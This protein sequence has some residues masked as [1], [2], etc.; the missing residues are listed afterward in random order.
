[1]EYLLLRGANY[2]RKLF[3]QFFTTWKLSICI[4]K[5]QYIERTSCK[6]YSK[7]WMF[8]KHLS[9]LFCGDLQNC[10][11]Y[12]ENKLLSIKGSK[13][14]EKCVSIKCSVYKQLHTLYCKNNKLVI[15]KRNEFLYK[16]YTGH[17]DLL[18]KSHHLES[19][20]AVSLRM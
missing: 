16:F 1:M 11:T 9:I 2:L 8:N 19:F 18:T 15:S 14:Q 10:K 12:D 17:L 7:A 20:T 5:L 4:V 3:S 13:R 6:M